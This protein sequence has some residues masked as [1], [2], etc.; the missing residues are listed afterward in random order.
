MDIQ[1]VIPTDKSDWIGLVVSILIC[2]AVAG[3]GSLATNPEIPNW[4][5]AIRKPAWTP[6]NWLF[7]PVWTAL[8]LAMAVAAWLVWKRAGWEANNNALWLFVIQLALNLAWSFI[9]FKFHNPALALIDILFLWLAILLTAV[10]FAGVSRAAALLLV[11]YLIWVT[12]AASLN[13]AI[14]RMND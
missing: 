2:F 6:P 1:N 12:Y 10:K 7:G 14:W 11:P 8:Y 4:Y 3:L 9:F 13:F 5:Q